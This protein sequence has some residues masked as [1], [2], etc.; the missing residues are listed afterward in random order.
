MDAIHLGALAIPLNRLPTLAALA[1]LFVAAA[2]IGRRHPRLNAWA[3]ET[4]LVALICA[5]AGFV[6]FN[7]PVYAAN[8]V[9][10]LY[11]WQGGFVPVIGIAA[12]LAYTFWRLRRHTES[13]LRAGI[14]LAAAGLAFG[15]GTAA[16]SWMAAAPRP[17]PDLT[18]QT[19]SGKPDALRDH[20][21][22]PLIVNLWATW[23]PPCRREMPMLTE[24]ARSR[25]DVT[26]LLVNQGEER[27]RVRQ[28]LSSENLHGDSVRLDPQSRASVMLMV[29]A[30]P[31]TLVYDGRGRLVLRHA[32]EVSR[33]F[34]HNAIRKARGE[35]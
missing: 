12:A 23:C 34:I 25:S 1:A 31:T 18:V 19:L 30:F 15:V 11:V 2:L 35:R 27:G 4:A 10:V 32:G 6:A 3:A 7:W 16:A 21:G 8:P 22:G 26:V 28:Y 5:R 29:D 9:T 33:A 20:L 17:L 13:L 24:V 14:P